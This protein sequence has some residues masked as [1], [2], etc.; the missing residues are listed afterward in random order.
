MAIALWR[1]SLLVASRYISDIRSGIIFAFLLFT[2]KAAAAQSQAAEEPI[3]TPPRMTKLRYD[4]SYAYLRNPINHQGRWWEP[5]KY[6]PLGTSESAYVTLGLEARFRHEDYRNPNWGETPQDNYQWYR[7]MPYGDVHLSPSVRLFGQL[8]G[9]R[10]EGKETPKTGFDDTGAEALQAFMEIKH[11]A[12]PSLDVDFRAGRWLMAYG[13]ERLLGVRYGPNVLRSFKGGRSR[14]ASGPWQAD[15]FFLRPVQA[16][17]GSW[18]DVSNDECAIAGVYMTRYL[19]L[20]DRSGGVDIYYLR[21]KN[22]SAEF[23]QDEA[24]ELRHT[25]GLRH[26]KK[27]GK[28]WDWDIEGAWQWGTF[29][30]ADIRAWTIA[31]NTGYTF[32]SMPY[33]PRIGVQMN[34]SSGDSNLN[35]RRLGTFNPL[36]PNN[37]IFGEAGILGPGN[38]INLN[39]TLALDLPHRVTLQ[40]A[41]NLY[42]RHKTTDG[43]Y[44]PG[45]NIVR[46]PGT[47]QSRWVGTQ[48]DLG[49]G[50]RPDRTIS[51]EIFYS[52]F[53][54]GSFVRQTG[55]SK[56]TRLIGAEFM[57][58]F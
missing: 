16:K 50:W 22:E 18:N 44:D 9:S 45:V 24:T 4:E 30:H 26:F 41:T 43:I 52:V 49:L 10:A 53:E 34:I 56:T 14:L 33:S 12:T 29:D 38:L 51:A 55:T 20:T 27:P 11:Q 40:A 58:K 3:V 17:V 2:F 5:Y 6:L 23:L 19:N 48:A 25:V 13:A 42:W 15:A 36:F 7:F 32:K 37:K 1:K 28:E 35:D 54:P 57:F 21:Y 47:S 39:P 46:R 8:I 31:T